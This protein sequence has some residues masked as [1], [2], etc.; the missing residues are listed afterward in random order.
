MTRRLPLVPIL[1]SVSFAI[2]IL[3]FVAI[4][5]PA[6]ESGRVIVTLRA[7][8]F[9]I[10]EGPDGFSVDVDGFGHLTVPGKPFLPLKRYLIALPPGARAVSV[11]L[12]DARP[13][14][15]PGSFRVRPAS[16]PMP[17]T[18]PARTRRVME[19]LRREWQ[20]NH[21]A[22]YESDAPYPERIAWLAGTGS[23]R[24]YAYASVA[25]CPFAYRPASG[26]LSFYDEARIAVRYEITAAALEESGAHAHRQ[27]P[28]TDA[29]AA[30]LF[31]NFTEMAGRYDPGLPSE[32]SRSETYDYVVVT[33]ADL[34][35]AVAASDFLSWKTTL[36]YSMRVV[37]LSD[38]EIAN[39]P[40]GDLAERIRNFLREQYATWGIEYVLLVGD[41]ATVPMRLCWPNPDYHV[42][43]PSDPGIVGG[44]TPTDYY[45]AD[46]SDPDSLSWDSD[47]DGFLGEYGEDLPDFLAEVAVG[48]IPV[49]DS[50]RVVYALDKIVVFEQDAGPW[51]TSALHAGA[52]LFYENEDH[53]GG[54]FVDGATCLDSIERG[55]MN[56]WTI[57][58]MSEQE[59]LSPSSFP[60]LAI[61]EGRFTRKWRNETHAVVNWSGHGW[62]NGAARTIWSWDDGDGVPEKDGSDGFYSD[63]FINTG[64]SVLEDDHPSIVFAISCNV[65]FPEPYVLGNLGID[66]LTLPGWGS[67]AGVVSSSR[68][69]AVSGDWMNSPGGTESICYE[70]NRYMIAEEE[71]VGDALYDGKWHATTQYGWEMYYEWM[72]LYQ[73]NL[74]GDPSLALGGI[75]TSVAGGPDRAA[76]TTIR[77]SRGYPNPFT[78]ATTVRLNLAAREKVRAHVYDIAG[79]RVASIADRVFG[80]GESSIV[81]NGIDD[82]GRPVAAGL[83]FLSVKT[84][85]RTVVRKIVR[86]R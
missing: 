79:R 23:L 69:A 52:I 48:R 22:A 20:V 17:L 70:F 5:D 7:D 24:R 43:D 11:E 12:L 9:R 18:E 36:G 37:L 85:K 3:A 59:G 82:T 10:E 32:K 63:Y 31:A 73:F 67:S 35:G 76:A 86:L 57:T 28:G 74:Y 40:G 80:A 19:E 75:P 2:T 77:V 81:W 61:T 51:K 34:D 60:W 16:S 38:D 33:T 47:G 39:Q 56:G 54:P 8:D 26:R 64:S 84:E 68:P 13:I 50:S 27:D 83:Y 62:C 4:A 58:H 15:Q 78:S 65:G 44:G 42:Y 25:F 6:V 45:Y 55:L 30:R 46:L 41:Y 71:R 53:G 72:D 1:L 21:D 49:N 14:D 66:L 29:K